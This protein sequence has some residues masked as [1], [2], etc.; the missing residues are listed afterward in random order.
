MFCT[1]PANHM[2]VLVEN[3]HVFIQPCNVWKGKMY[4]IDEYKK[5]KAELVTTLKDGYHYPGCRVC[6]DED[7]K[8]IRSRRETSS[9]SMPCAKRRSAWGAS[10]AARV[11]T[12]W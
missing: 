8:I 9:H 12:G 10:C 4:A 1:Q 7:K 11:T 3:Q 5:V 2:D 6:F